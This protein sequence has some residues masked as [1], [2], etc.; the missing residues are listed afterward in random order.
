M[1]SFPGVTRDV[2]VLFWHYVHLPHM[3]F[4]FDTDR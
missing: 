4:T 1:N 2:L 3:E